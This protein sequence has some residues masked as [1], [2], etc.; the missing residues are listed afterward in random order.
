MTAAALHSWHDRLPSYA[1]LA[2][3][4]AA[5]GLP[6]ALKMVAI[7]LLAATGLKEN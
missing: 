7:A 6:G 1:L 3:L 4:L 5:A 2:G